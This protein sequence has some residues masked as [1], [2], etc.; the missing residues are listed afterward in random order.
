MI[1]KN[2]FF[3]R[4]TLRAA[5][6]LLGKVLVRKYRGK[7]SKLLITEVEAYDG[8]HDKASHANRGRTERTKPMFEEGGVFYIYFTY[9]MHWLVNIVT[10]PKNY[11]AAIL[12]RAG[13]LLDNNPVLSITAYDNAFTYEGVQKIISPDGLFTI[14]RD[15]RQEKE[16]IKKYFINGPAR[17]TKTL[18]I[19]KKLNT[20]KALPENSLWFEYGI[21][22]RPSQ[23]LAKKRTGVDYAGPKWSIK[24]YKFRID[25]RT[26]LNQIAKV[27]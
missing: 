12:I 18:K 1:L 11:P 3:K 19:N 5:K 15:S 7:E 21:K 8:P 17:I 22:I 14:T 13:I 16:T 20:K 26:A 2:K 6:D 9:G 25:P 4:K 23:I 27:I 10:G 24:P